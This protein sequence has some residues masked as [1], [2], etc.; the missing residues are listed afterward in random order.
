VM[1]LY[2][3]ADM[4]AAVRD[5]ENDLSDDEDFFATELDFFKAQHVCYCMQI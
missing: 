1:Q 5:H 2:E 4:S 3:P